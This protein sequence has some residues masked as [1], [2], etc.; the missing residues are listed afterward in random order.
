MAPGEDTDSGLSSMSSSN[1]SLTSGSKDKDISPEKAKVEFEDDDD[2]DDEDLDETLSE[3]LWGLTEMFPEGVRNVT[4]TVVSGTCTG[5]KGLYGFS[6][7]ATWLFF[8]TSVLL[9]AP[10]IFE[11]ER[12][13]MEEV[14]RS[15]Q[16]QV[17]LG[18]GS[19]MSGGMGLLP[20]VQR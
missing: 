16:K 19:A 14:Q 9:F 20:Q 12:A 3:R 18:P 17:L 1:R 5:M 4:S 10:L 11:V 8:S 6:R 15:Q 7:T 13:Q 2:L